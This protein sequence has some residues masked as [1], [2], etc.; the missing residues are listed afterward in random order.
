[1]LYAGCEPLPRDAKG[2]GLPRPVVRQGKLSVSA[3]DAKWYLVHLEV[4]MTKCLYMMT[5]DDNVLKRHNK[6]AK[7]A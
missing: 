6:Q 5:W 7:T 3:G 2:K 1:M 4:C